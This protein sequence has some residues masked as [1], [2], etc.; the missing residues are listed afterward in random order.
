MT[1]QASLNTM[2]VCVKCSEENKNCQRQCHIFHTHVTLL[3]SFSFFLG[4]FF[5]FCRHD[6]LNPQIIRVVG[7]GTVKHVH[8]IDNFPFVFGFI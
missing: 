7:R 4:F 6:L 1:N 2:C 3:L 5:S 8:E